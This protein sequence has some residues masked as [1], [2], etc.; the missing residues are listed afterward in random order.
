[1]RLFIAIPVPENLHRYCKQIQSKFDGLKNVS[2]FHLTLQFLGDGIE[3]SDEIKES[4]S[5][6][7]FEPFEIE[8]GDAIPFGPPKTPRGAWIECKESPALSNL[9]GQIRKQMSSLGFQ[10]DKLFRAHITLGRYKRPPRKLPQKIEGMP[11]QFKVDHF[12]LIQSHLSEGGPK[13]KTLQKFS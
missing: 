1:M 9:A 4:L 7:R 6:I 10:S 13:Y 2:D 12:E 8:M 3:S 5:Q 11:H